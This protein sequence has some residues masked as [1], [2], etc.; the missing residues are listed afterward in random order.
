MK[1]VTNKLLALDCFSQMLGA[2]AVRVFLFGTSSMET[3]CSEG[4]SLS[5]ST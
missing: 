5:I 1:I 3:L 2:H 4:S